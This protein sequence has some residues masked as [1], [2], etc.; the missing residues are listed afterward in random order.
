MTITIDNVDD[1]IAGRLQAEAR[2]RGT[3]VAVVAGEA[4]RRGTS[5]FAAPQLTPDSSTAQDGL[6]ALA[7]TWGEDD[8]SAF[9]RATAD[10]RRVDK[11]LWE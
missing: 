5:A 4:L 7:G 2:R 1:D 11:G 10:F 9:D 8:A 6:T 3:D